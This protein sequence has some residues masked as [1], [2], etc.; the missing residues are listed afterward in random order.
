MKKTAEYATIYQ[1]ALFNIQ[2][3]KNINVNYEFDWILKSN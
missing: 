2:M 1:D 3:I